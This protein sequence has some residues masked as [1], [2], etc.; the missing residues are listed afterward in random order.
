MGCIGLSA[1]WAAKWKAF[2]LRRRMRYFAALVVEAR[3]AKPEL[4]RYLESLESKAENQARE[5]KALRWTLAGEQLADWDQEQDR[6]EWR[7]R[8]AKLKGPEK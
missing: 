6:L 2:R 4:L 8:P 5:L 3:E 7:N 1:I